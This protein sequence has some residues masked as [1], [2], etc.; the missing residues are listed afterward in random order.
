MDKQVIL[1]KI[2]RINENN[3]FIEYPAFKYFANENTYD[4]ITEFL[5]DNFN[6]VLKN[7]INFNIH[8][9]LK[10][11]TI[12]EVE[13]HYNY[14]GKICGIFNND[15]PDSNLDTCYIYNAPFIFSQV[16]SIL[17]I[18]I[19]KVTCKKIKLVKKEK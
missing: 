10:S 19:D 4:E 7:H 18:F 3:I 2:C 6:K 8:L 16:L 5:R 1:E 9:S 12:K 14:I 15:F 13:K 11:L 17:S